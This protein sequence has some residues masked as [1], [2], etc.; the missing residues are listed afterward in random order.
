[1]KE[2]NEMG[3]LKNGMLRLEEGEEEKDQRRKD[4]SIKGK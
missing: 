4:G 1:M 3:R 2:N